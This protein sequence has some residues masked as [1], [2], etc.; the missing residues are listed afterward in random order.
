MD[1]NRLIVVYSQLIEV[2]QACGYHDHCTDESVL[3]ELGFIVYRI[4]GM[5]GGEKIWQ[6]VRDSPNFNT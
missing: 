2:M 1:I 4:A 6:V 3:K 5:F